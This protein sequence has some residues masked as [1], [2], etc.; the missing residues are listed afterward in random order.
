MGQAATPLRVGLVVF[1]WAGTTVDFGC[2]GPVAAFREVFVE[3]GIA[4]STEQLRAPM[5]LPKRD[6]LE[7]VLRLPVVAERW[8]RRHGRQWDESDVK[9]LYEDFVGRQLAV[10]DDH[11]RIVRGLP[12]CVAELRRRGLPIAAT[13]GY[14]RAAA[15]R[16]AAAAARQG[17]VPDAALCPDDVTAGRPAPWMM[18]RHMERFGVYPPAAVVKVGDTVADVEEGRNAGAWTIGVTTTGSLVGLDET[19]WNALP[20]EQQR[21]RQA[22]ARRTLLAAGAHAVI[23]DLR[24]LPALLD[25]LNARLARGERP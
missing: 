15:E 1:D 21:T 16:V 6:H 13:T 18:F 25:E 9:A 11:S 17:Y 24:E 19:E 2:L 7:A 5:G 12:A 23:D 8:L 4:V 3:R 20:P 14:F 22:A 10:L